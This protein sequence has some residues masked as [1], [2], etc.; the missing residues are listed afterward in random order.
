[1][2]NY[3]AFYI[4]NFRLVGSESF[5]AA[6]DIDAT[7]LS[8]RASRGRAFELWK[9]N[10]RLRLYPAADLVTWSHAAPPFPENPRPLIQPHAGA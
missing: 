5:E 7:L 6:D 8:L 9:G 2:Q 10:N 3:R 1:M 4:D